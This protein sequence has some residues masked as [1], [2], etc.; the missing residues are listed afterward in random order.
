MRWW[1]AFF[2]ITLLARAL[3][4]TELRDQWAGRLS[5][6]ER[7][8]GYG[9]G[10]TLRDPAGTWQTL[11]AV[12]LG[13]E[14][15]CAHFLLPHTGS[16]DGV[17]RVT[18]VAL[19]DTCR[20]QWE[21]KPVLELPRLRSLQFSLKDR[22]IGL[23]W[24]QGDGRVHSLVA[25]TPEISGVFFFPPDS[26]EAVGGVEL[27]GKLEDVWP[28]SPCSFG[29]GSCQLCRYGVYQVPGEK[30]LYHCGVG[31]CGEANQPACARGTRWAN[32][33]GPFTCRGEGPHFFCAQGLRVE[34]LGEVPFCR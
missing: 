11:F 8:E 14:K 15:H 7:H 17:L 3:E 16:D 33:R 19:K 13:D 21:A 20:G 12:V 22:E 23:W 32:Q 2:F 9:D 5:V 1:V 26:D 18:R 29:D 28:A 25:K 6:T 27:T 34:C 4:P 10:E 24:T 30:D 31:A